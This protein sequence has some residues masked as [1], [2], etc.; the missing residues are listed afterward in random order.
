MAEIVR[1]LCEDIVRMGTGRLR[2]G[3]E[4]G[5]KTLGRKKGRREWQE[6]MEQMDREGRVWKEGVY[7]YVSIYS[8]Y[9]VYI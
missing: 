2:K 9:S 3:N 7:R 1:G 4:R 8:I 6:K 5:R